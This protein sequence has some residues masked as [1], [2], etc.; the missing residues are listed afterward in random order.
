MWLVPVFKKFVDLEEIRE[1]A[2]LENV[3]IPFVA[4]RVG[5]TE[6]PPQNV[7]NLL[8]ATSARFGG[9]RRRR[10]RSKGK[11]QIVVTAKNLLIGIQWKFNAGDAHANEGYSSRS[12]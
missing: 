6:T 9:V 1:E 11:Q 2:L 4:N 7:E 5:R 3:K 8:M 12:I 10:R